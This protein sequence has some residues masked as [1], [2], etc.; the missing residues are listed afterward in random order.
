[1]STRRKTRVD[2]LFKKNKNMEKIIRKIK[3]Q[4][5]ATITRFICWLSYGM[6]CYRSVPNTL[7]IYRSY[8][9]DNLKKE[10]NILLEIYSLT[11]LDCEYLKKIVSVRAS[12]GILRLLEM[13]ENKKMQ[14]TYN[15]LELKKMIEDTLGIK[16]EEMDWGEYRYQQKLRPLFLWNIENGENE[17]KRK[18]ELYNIVLLVME[19]D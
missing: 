13:H 15:H 16:I 7:E 6:G 14:I 11:E 10:L 18:L 3:L 5:K 8:T 17:I 1:M 2:F 12:S 9:F 19:E 4:L